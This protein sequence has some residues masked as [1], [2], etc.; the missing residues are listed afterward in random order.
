[1]LSNPIGR[2]RL[3]GLLE[4][5]SFLLLLF[6]AMPL[7]YAAGLPEAVKYVGWAHGAL[8]VLFIAALLHASSETGWSLGK[9][10]GAFIAS[11][12]PFGTFILDRTLKRD[13]AALLAARP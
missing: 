13:E 9:I 1:M 3:I 2:L 6:V 7:K 12:L 11:V 4:G 8:F 10:A 5:T